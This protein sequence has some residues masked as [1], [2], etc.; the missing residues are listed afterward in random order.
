MERRISLGTL[1]LSPGRAVIV[2]L[3]WARGKATRGSLIS[4][5]WY[6]QDILPM[7]RK[8]IRE[9]LDLKDPHVFQLSTAGPSVAST[10]APLFVDR[11]NSEEKRE[12]E[13]FDC[14]ASPR[15]N[16]PIQHST[17]RSSMRRGYEDKSLCGQS[18]Q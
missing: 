1:C 11:I 8:Q 6:L 18:D 4:P 3:V 5:S 15:S 9:S 7:Q 17:Q 10:K 16:L 12:R 13:P 2:V 14:I